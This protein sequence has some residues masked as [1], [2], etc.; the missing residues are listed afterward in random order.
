MRN[1]IFTSFIMLL[2]MATTSCQEEDPEPTSTD[3][4]I[5]LKSEQVIE[6]DNQF[7]FELLN[8]IVNEETENDNLMVSPMSVSLALAMVYNGA[9]G[10]T[11]SQMEEMLHKN[12][13]SSTDINKAY[14]NLVEALASHDPEVELSIANSIFYN[15]AYSL[16]QAFLDTNR[17]YYEAEIEGLDFA[18]SNGTLNT[19]NNW[20]KAKTKDKI[21]SILDQVSPNDVLYLINAIYFKG[22]WTYQFDEQETHD[23]AF[24]IKS[25]TEVDVP[26]M[27]I[28][29]SFN[30][31][32]QN[33]FEL[34]ELPYG[35][36]KY[37]M[38]IFLPHEGHSANEIAALLNPNNIE[39]WLEDMYTT[40]KTVYF[41]KFEFSYQNSL[42]D[43]L[44]LLGMQDAFSTTDADF[45]GI[46]NVYLYISEVLHKSYIKVDEEGTE[47][48]AV[49][50]ITFETT[51][52]GQESIFN[53]DHPFIFAIREKDTNAILFIGKVSNPLDNGE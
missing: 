5:S 32:S 19:V 34:L 3:I 53:V 6:A 8:L 51:S 10:D 27:T 49:T 17:Y 46:A 22:E 21:E 29:E 2:I 36:D 50:A 38:L 44:R 41:P 7:G 30:Y 28:K 18:D 4:Q 24:Q 23:R 14:K 12:G 52:M 25:G 16:N 9:E 13:L 26:T 31:T 20:V 48:A 47:A 1:L 11:K 39:M 15:Q 42:V 37:S 35:S 45:S 43:N 40:S 33:E